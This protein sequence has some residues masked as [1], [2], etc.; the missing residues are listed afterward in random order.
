MESCDPCL[1]NLSQPN[2]NNWFIGNDTIIC[3]NESITIISFLDPSYTLIWNDGQLGSTIQ[4]NQQGT[5]WVTIVV[6]DCTYTTDTISISKI[7]C[8]PCEYFIPNAFSPN[9]D[10]FNDFFQVNFSSERM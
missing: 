6:D 7:D 2:L 3:E 1:T 9:A 10:G 5:Y 8:T 4:A